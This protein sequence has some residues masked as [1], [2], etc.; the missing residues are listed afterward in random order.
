MRGC[1]LCSFPQKTLKNQINTSDFTYSEDYCQIRKKQPSA[2]LIWCH[3]LGHH[4][5]CP[6]RTN[7]QK[8]E[9]NG[10]REFDI[11]CLAD[12]PTEPFLS[13]PSHPLP[14]GDMFKQIQRPSFSL[15]R[16]DLNVRCQS[17]PVL[18]DVLDF[19]LGCYARSIAS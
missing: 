8:V 3:R 18:E 14:E 2:L 17:E 13:G 12:S 11:H 6:R 7:R 4:A 15:D 1:S 9:V 16:N 5:K 19:A 10:T